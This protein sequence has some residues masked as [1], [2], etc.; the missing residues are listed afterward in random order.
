MCVAPSVFAFL[1]RLL[2][3]KTNYKYNVR[4][5]F[6]ILDMPRK[7]VHVYVFG[8][9]HENAGFSQR[10]LINRAI[11]FRPMGKPGLFIRIIE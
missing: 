1:C 10:A 4:V 9:L 7:F 6:Q 8:G 3:G 2:L 5:F 11:L